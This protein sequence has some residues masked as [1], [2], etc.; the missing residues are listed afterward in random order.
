[1][2]KNA[3]RLNYLQ[4]NRKQAKQRAKSRAHP[5]KVLQ[6]LEEKERG[7]VPLL[8][9]VDVPAPQAQVGAL[10]YRGHGLEGI[11]EIF[12]FWARNVVDNPRS[13]RLPKRRSGMRQRRRGR[14]TTCLLACVRLFRA[15]QP[16]LP[17]RTNTNAWNQFCDVHTHRIA[18]NDEGHDQSCKVHATDTA[19]TCAN[20]HSKNIHAPFLH[21]CCPSDTT[22]LSHITRYI[23][24]CTF[25]T[26]NILLQSK[27]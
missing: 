5:S 19:R 6:L 25:F 12:H 9:N 7:C 27:Q 11:R 24:R 23:P 22:Y 13:G 14:M 10:Y 15:I 16:T 18:T 26:L 1:M 3:N 2:V 20:M 21:P 8:R 17:T 4:Q